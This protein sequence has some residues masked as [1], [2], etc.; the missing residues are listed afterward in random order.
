MPNRCPSVPITPWWAYAIV[1]VIIGIILAMFYGIIQLQKN[2]FAKDPSIYTKGCNNCSSKQKT[3]VVD[4][5]SVPSV[6]SML[7]STSN[8]ETQ[9]TSPTTANVFKAPRSKLTV[10][11]AQ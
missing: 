11:Y 9:T 6:T 4:I 1:F 10:T 5:N 3:P 7:C 2:V 8:L